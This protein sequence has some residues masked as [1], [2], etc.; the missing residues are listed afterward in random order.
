MT[1]RAFGRPGSAH[2]RRGRFWA[3]LIGFRHRAARVLV[4]TVR[5][6]GVDPDG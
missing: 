5:R 2:P 4:A 1:G 6:H 3:A